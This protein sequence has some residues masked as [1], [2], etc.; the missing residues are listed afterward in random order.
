MFTMKIDSEIELQLLQSQHAEEFFHLINQNR[1]FLKKWLPWVNEILSPI[2][3]QG[4]IS[5]WLIQLSGHNGFSFGI[6]YKGR[7]VGN[8]G[9]QYIDWYNRQTSIGYFL[10]E[11]AVGKGIM[12]RS[13]QAVLNYI[14]F[15]LRLN[16]IEI[17]CGEKNLKSRAIPE[18]LG[19]T[20]EGFVRDGENLNGQFHHLL[21]YSMLA[22]EWMGK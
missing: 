11:D 3:T 6:R 21:M 12:T 14:F 19:F 1:T 5:F 7:L 22:R 20:Y 13:V 4:L 9:S 15:E 18:R 10:A 17:R 16:R 8:I 2:Q